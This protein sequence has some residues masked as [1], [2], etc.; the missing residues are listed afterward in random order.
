[1][2]T[3]T[4]IQFAAKL[5]KLFLPVGSRVT[6]KCTDRSDW[7]FVAEDTTDNRMM[8]VRMGFRPVARLPKL[9]SNTLAI[10]WTVK[11]G[12]RFEVVIVKNMVA[13]QRVWKAILANRHLRDLEHSL[14]DDRNARRHLW[15]TLYKVYAR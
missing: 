3:M 14:K 1:M 7:D 6:G 11:S 10:Y 13:K 15:N 9:D 4:S 5:T 2:G 8:L 12:T